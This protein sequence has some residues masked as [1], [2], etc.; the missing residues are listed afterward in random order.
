MA[1]MTGCLV[2]RSVRVLA[3]GGAS[4]ALLLIACGPSAPAQVQTGNP[5]SGNSSAAPGAAPVTLEQ[6]VAGAK[7]EGQ[8]SVAAPTNLTEAQFMKIVDALNK[9]YGLSLQGSYS[10]GGNLQDIVAKV[11]QE[12]A[13]GGTTTW[14]SVLLNDSYLASLAA[15]GDLEQRPYVDV[16]HAKPD[17]LGFG[18]TSVA[19][20]N[21]LVMPAVN[22][23]LV[24]ADQW[25][26]TWDDLLD[27]KW[28]GRISAHNATHHWVRLSRVWGDQKTTDFVTRL[29]AQEPKLG[30]INE[31]FQNTVLGTTLLSATQTNSQMD[32][33]RKKGE[34]IDWVPV[35]PVV[36]P[37]YYC[38]QVKGAPH[39]NAAML[40]CGYM[41]TAE[42]QNLWGETVGHQSIADPTTDLGKIYAAN[43]KDVVQWDDLMPIDDFNKLDTKYRTILGFH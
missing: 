10:A 35:R 21:Q 18:G 14:D 3:L 19:F 24:P 27:P 30:L 2:L 36:A 20:A 29:A 13:T 22:T 15:D 40:F 23:R 5:A 12:R 6:L 9:Q 31:T 41:L 8:L 26:K 4:L 37:N 17:L 39:P 34:P 28:K 42:A 38:S 43:P 25:P 32:T 16:F 1:R 11:I 7:K 33:A